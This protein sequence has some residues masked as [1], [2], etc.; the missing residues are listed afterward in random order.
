MRGA[1]AVI[2]A[3]EKEGV[4]YISGFAGGGLAPLWEPLRVS[5]SIQTFAA[6]HER[7]GV[8]S[9]HIVDIASVETDH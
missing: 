4:R 2:R 6:R 5:D 1:E 3:L 9:Q 8:G 7:L